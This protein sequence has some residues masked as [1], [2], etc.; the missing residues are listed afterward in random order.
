[1]DKPKVITKK[2]PKQQLLDWGLPDENPAIFDESN[3]IVSEGKIYKNKYV[4]KHRWN[5][6]YELIFSEPEDN[7]KVW[8]TYYFVGNTEYQEERPWEYENEVECTLVRQVEKVKVVK[9]WQEVTEDYFNE[10]Y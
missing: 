2:F 1:M 8:K 4:E 3:N 6:L 9:V 5:S 10:F 7:T